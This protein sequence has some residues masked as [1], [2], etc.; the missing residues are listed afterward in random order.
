MHVLGCVADDFTGAT[1]IG[2]ALVR[3][4][5]RTSVVVT[6]GS[7]IAVEG[8]DA[9]VV[10]LK[11]RTI[12]AA[13]AVAASL[14]AVDALAAAGA[15][16]FYFKYCSTFDSTPEGNIGPVT[17]AMLERL[18][19]STALMVPSFPA[20]GRTVYRGHLFV[21]DELLSE[22]SMRTHPLTP[23]T[24]SNLAAVLAPQTTHPVRLI[25]LDI[26]RSSQ[27]ELLA[28]IESA[29]GLIIVDAIDD[30]DLARIAA[31]APPNVLMTGGAGLAAQ[32]EGGP[33]GSD[34]ASIRVPRGLRLIVSGSASRMTRA[35]VTSAR[36]ELPSLK[37]DLDAIRTDAVG[38]ASRILDWAMQHWSSDPDIPV[39]VFATETE[40]DVAA[41]SE[42]RAESS[43]LIESV[44]AWVAQESVL[45]GV[46]QIIVAG[47]ETSGAVVSALG[48]DR[49]TIGPE[50]APGVVWSAATTGDGDD[51]AIALKSGNFGDPSLFTTAWDRLE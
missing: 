3:A 46:R 18:G 33:A 44:L 8:L 34:A 27:E 39:L 19:T 49:L 23:M 43:E 13:D 40:G 24:D 28:A 48:I 32:L 26:V 14:A 38:E 17:D 2:A 10:A 45:A 7:A 12:P 21:G 50:I 25:T 6:L 41:S 5:Y 22:S 9:I 42:S 20:N 1:D 30:G 11:S 36:T 4:G 31:A 16:R 51:I 15:D 37:L 29:P 47:G 35:Q